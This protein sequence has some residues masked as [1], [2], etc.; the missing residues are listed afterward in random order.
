MLLMVPLLNK[1]LSEFIS[2]EASADP[3]SA[4]DAAPPSNITDPSL[5]L[6]TVIALV[7]FLLILV[8]NISINAK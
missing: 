1:S 3:G 4:P 5:T 6:M 8:V 7:S 2:V